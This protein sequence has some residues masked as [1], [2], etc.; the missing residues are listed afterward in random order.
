IKTKDEY[1]ERYKEDPRLPSTPYRPYPDFPG[2][3]A[4][5]GKEKRA[6]LY[7]TWQEASAAAI[8]LG[9]KTKDEYKERYK[10]DPRLPSTPY[11]TYSDFP[12]FP[13]FFGKNG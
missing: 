5:L 8:G 12:D 11:K 13:A 3:T 4:F 10:E 7:P 9:I 1:K 2:F 6:D